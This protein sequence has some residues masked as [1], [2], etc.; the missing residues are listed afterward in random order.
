MF[1][2]RLAVV[3]IGL[4]VATPVLA[5]KL[6]AVATGSIGSRPV[7]ALSV[8]PPMPSALRPSLP[9]LDD[10]LKTHPPLR[11][12]TL[13]AGSD[14]EI[15]LRPKE[16][17]LSFDDGP[18]TG[19]TEGVLNILDAF[20]VK[21]IFM[22]VG[23]MAELHPQSAQAV[24]LDGQTIGTHTYDHPNLAKLTPAAALEEIRHG[25]EA[26]ASVLLA[27]VHATPSPFFRFPY[28]ATTWFLQATLTFE[29]TIVL[30]VQI[31][32]DDYMKDTPADTL[33]RML[34]R[35]DHVGK[36]IVLFH[37]I[38]PKTQWCCRCSS[39]P[40]RIAATPWCNLSAKRRAR[41]T[42]R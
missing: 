2:F 40:V 17:I 36:G 1:W 34:A 20:G 29:S 8:V 27:P 37:D 31:D 39:R 13:A 19:R 28:L 38:H 25:Q 33:R 3:S 14:A 5:G 30:G 18:T 7:S 24:A 22:M 10:W 21:A 15:D 9:L 32:S 6:D 42:S 41:S 16:V 23:K 4:S 26:V 35:L 11:G 12:R